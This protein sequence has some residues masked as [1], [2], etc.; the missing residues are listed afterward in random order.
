MILT[1]PIPPNIANAR[2]HW[3]AKHRARRAYRDACTALWVARKIPRAN[4][5]LAFAEVSAHLYVWSLM[6]D[7]NA[8]ARMKFALDWCV[9]AGYLMGDSRKHLRWEHVPNQTVDRKNPRLI[10]TLTEAQTPTES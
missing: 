5:P 10:L 2:M 8:M 4:K 3:T 1:L 9:H 6:D 7:D